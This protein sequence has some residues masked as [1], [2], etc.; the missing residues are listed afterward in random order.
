MSR[1]KIYANL[2][3][4]ILMLAITAFI[5]DDVMFRVS[6]HSDNYR[7]MGGYVDTNRYHLQIIILLAILKWT[8]STTIIYFFLSRRIGWIRKTVEIFL[9]TCSFYALEWTI[10]KG[11][12]LL[13]SDQPKIRMEWDFNAIDTSIFYL[14]LLLIAVALFYLR[15][16][17]IHF[18]DLKSVFNQKLMLRK[19]RAQNEPHFLFN[20]LNSIY[21]LSIRMEV[22]EITEALDKL[23]SNLRYVYRHQNSQLVSAEEEVANA[24]SYVDLQRSRIDEGN[25]DIR[26]LQQADLDHTEYQLPPLSFLNY[27]E[28]AFQHGISYQN[29]SYIYLQVQED[30]LGLHLEIE[31]SVHESKAN[32]RGEGLALSETLLKESMKKGSYDLSIEKSDMFFKVSLLLKR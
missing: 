1:R 23:T 7:N 27:V 30:D 29:R 2:F 10:M 11:V 17:I 19:I 18:D 3:L 32:K 28:N 12:L 25:V 16:S 9:Y 22:P 14:I 8:F 31:N 13:L 21:A 15:L 20:S 24:I 26:I 5:I 4:I 6:L